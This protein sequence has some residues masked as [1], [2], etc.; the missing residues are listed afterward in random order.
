M[1]EIKYIILNDS[2]FLT[3]YGSG[4]AVKKVM[5]PTV[6]VPQHWDMSIRVHLTGIVQTDKNFLEVVQYRNR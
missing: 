6:P 2:D 1:K 5:A 4:S 3:R